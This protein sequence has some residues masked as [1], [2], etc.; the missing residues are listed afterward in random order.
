MKNKKR[1][2][3]FASPFIT[4]A[5]LGISCIALYGCS[6][7]RAIRLRNKSIKEWSAYQ[8]E[9]VKKSSDN[10]WTIYSRKLEGTNFLEFKIEG[11]ISA[12]SEACLASFKEDIHNESDDL[13]NKQYPTYEI[14]E[15]SEESL[16]TYVIH[17]EPFPLKNT[18]MSIRYKF[19]K[20]METSSHKISWKESWEEDSVPPPSKKL[21][22][23]KT[24]RG[25]WNFS[26]ISSL[27]CLAI[28][29]VQFDPGKMP[30][31][32]VNP[33]VTNF[34]I[35]GLARIREMNSN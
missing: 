13:E 2:N 4:V 3:T 1:K 14:V 10:G 6:T 35:K 16:L 7:Q 34:L 12:S 28:N 15:E 22:R 21:S 17:K 26:P 32:L 8:W 25:S 33:M 11:D 24:F 19:P 31:G 27:S 23:V 20:V 9:E 29:N 5:I 18:E 30:R